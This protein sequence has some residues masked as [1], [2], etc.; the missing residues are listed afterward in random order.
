MIDLILQWFLKNF[1]MISGWSSIFGFI[2]SIWVLYTV[3][4]LRNYYFLKGRIPEI[5]KEINKFSKDLNSYLADINNNK[6][7][8]VLIIKQCEFTLKSLKKKSTDDLVS[9]INKM[10]KRISKIKKGGPTNV[11]P[12]RSF[13]E[14]SF[15]DEVWEFYSDMQGLLQGLKENANDSKWSQE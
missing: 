3:S 13:L 8:I 4:R 5:T 7:E 15:D 9:L 2:L 11:I 10:L 6:S 12:F 14:W 1:N